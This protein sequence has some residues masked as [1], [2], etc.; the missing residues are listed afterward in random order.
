M[1][2]IKNPSFYFA[3]KFEPYANYFIH[4]DVEHL[5]FEPGKELTSPGTIN[6]T[7]FY[8]EQGCVEFS[9]THEKGAEKVLAIF[10]QGSLFP[11]GLVEHNDRMDFQITLR[12]LTPIAVRKFPYLVLRQFAEKHPNFA[13]ALLEENCDFISYL[14]HNAISQAYS[15]VQQHLAG[16][17]LLLGQSELSLDGNIYVTQELLA[18]LSGASR[19]QTERALKALREKNIIETN[20]KHIRIISY[21]KLTEEAEM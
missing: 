19:A 15:P 10:G 6:N 20:R 17:L 12:A 7:S 16:I 8:I 9:L 13:M 3:H 1:K 21:E 2:K 4:K 14:F 5:Q 11:I 18:N